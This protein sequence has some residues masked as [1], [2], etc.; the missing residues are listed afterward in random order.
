MPKI[1]RQVEE[2]AL[3]LGIG[4]IK[5]KNQP[6]WTGHAINLAFVF[7]DTMYVPMNVLF[8]E[9][10][11]YV[12]APKKYRHLPNFGWKATPA[13]PA[14]ERA[15]DGQDWEERRA[16]ILTY[17]ALRA[18]RRPWEAQAAQD[19][20]QKPEELL[21]AGEKL[22]EKGLVEAGTLRP[23]FLDGVLDPHGEP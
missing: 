9:I 6:L 23:L 5:D 22:V 3:K 15:R 10:A 1:S 2:V 19:F 16:Q 12:V 21:K 18:C 13:G 7:N 20:W 4:F 8:H 14:A 11:H 17:L